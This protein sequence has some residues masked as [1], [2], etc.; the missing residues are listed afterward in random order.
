MAYRDFFPP[1]NRVAGNSCL[2]RSS[3]DT[4]AGSMRT[5]SA[6]EPPPES[7]T[8]QSL[9]VEEECGCYSEALLWWEHPN[10]TQTRPC[11]LAVRAIASPWA[12]LAC[13]GDRRRF[14]L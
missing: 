13:G 11:S 4:V 6:E 12:D 7:K 14:R 8:H 9:Q 5:S 2:D 10:S 3:T 1:Q